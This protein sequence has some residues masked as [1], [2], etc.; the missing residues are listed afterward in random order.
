[1]TRALRSWGVDVSKSYTQ[2]VLV[3]ALHE[4]PVIELGCI[5]DRGTTR[6]AATSASLP[7]QHG[8]TRTYL[9]AQQT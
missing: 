6:A 5:N 4:L 7:Q 2:H 3:L 1:M 9:L 8:G